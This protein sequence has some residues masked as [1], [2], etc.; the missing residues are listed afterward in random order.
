MELRKRLSNVFY[1]SCLLASWLRHRLLQPRFPKIKITQTMSLGSNYGGKVFCPN[2]LRGTT[3]IS[4]G[5]GEDISFDVEIARMFELNVILI[6]PVP[7]SI[8]H[9]N[10]VLARIG[11]PST[12]GV[13]PIAGKQ[14]VNTY[15]LEGLK[16]SQLILIEKALFNHVGRIS[17]FPPLD[18]SHISHSFL[19]LHKTR[20]IIGYQELRVECTTVKAI[21]EEFKITDLSILKLDIEGAQLE[22]L[23]SMFADGIFPRQI[24]V[25]I[26][27]LHFPSLSSRRRAR[28]CLE[29]L[30]RNLYELIARENKYDLSFVRR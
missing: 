17:L 4:A 2:D 23:E 18:S 29:L 11:E 3:V 20:S 12:S 28:K 13:T 26:D 15:N 19:D 1:K 25:E 9:V 7:R 16:S 8:S 10:Q 30:A 27:E 21:V 14:E 22:V 5:C 24:L 6:D